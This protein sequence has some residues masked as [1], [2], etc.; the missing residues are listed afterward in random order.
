MIIPQFLYIPYCWLNVGMG[1]KDFPGL[2]SR[3]PSVYRIYEIIMLR[4][5]ANI[6][7]HKVFFL[8]KKCVV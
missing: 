7:I 5:D 1:V 6:N 8:V 4:V 3:I 2:S